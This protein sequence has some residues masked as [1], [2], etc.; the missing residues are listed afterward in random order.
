MSSGDVTHC[1]TSAFH[2]HFDY[3]FIVL[4]QTHTIKLLGARI[5][6]LK[7]QNQCPV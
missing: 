1:R 2:N 7:E 5:G 6:H 3:S 4:K